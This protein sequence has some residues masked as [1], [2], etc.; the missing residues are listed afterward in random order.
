MWPKTVALRLSNKSLSKQLLDQQENRAA[1]HSVSWRGWQQ[2]PAS[3]VSIRIGNH[4]LGGGTWA[5]R[6][7]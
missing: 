6:S 2:L 5:Q 1:D 4:Y 3:D 7:V